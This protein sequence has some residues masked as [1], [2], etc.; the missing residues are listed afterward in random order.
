MTN[1]KNY[2]FV[3]IVGLPGSGKTTL[4][5]KMYAEAPHGSYLADDFSLHM[6]EHLAAIDLS[7]TD[8]VIVTDPSLCAITC[9]EQAEHSILEIFELL[10]QNVA[11]EWIYFENDMEACLVNSK[12]APKPGGVDNFTRQLAKTY[13]IPPGAD[14]R[15]VYKVIN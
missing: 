4:A 5:E 14:V 10:P 8:V 15:P 12:R 9:Q 13:K 7:Q 2:K 3:M 11:F 6:E 1:S